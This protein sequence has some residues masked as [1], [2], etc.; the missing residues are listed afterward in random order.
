MYAP[1]T[2]KV[3]RTLA[4]ILFTFSTSCRGES[5]YRDLSEP[6]SMEDYLPPPSEVAP[7]TAS[8]AVRR[9]LQEHRRSISTPDEQT[10]YAFRP[11]GFVQ[12]Y[13]AHPTDRENERGMRTY[14]DYRSISSIRLEPFFDTQFLKDR[15]RMILEGDF[16]RW[17]S[18]IRAFQS[19]PDLG[20]E[21]ETRPVKTLTLVLDDAATAQLL[22]RAL[23][24]LSHPTHR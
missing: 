23:L 11:D 13:H 18:H 15:F 5:V 3:I 6:L 10:G 21:P 22:C 2:M 16:R 19:Q 9:S 24:L 4:W 12:L 1:P 20:A 8:L 7:D 14:V 17:E